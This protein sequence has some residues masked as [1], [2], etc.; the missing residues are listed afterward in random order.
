MTDKNIRVQHLIIETTRR[1]KL[2]CRHCLR[3]DAQDLDIDVLF[4]KELFANVSEIDTIT[5]TGGEPAMNCY[6]MRM[7]LS[8]AIQ[9]G[10]RVRNIYVATN[11]QDVSRDFLT[12]I[13]EW[14]EYCIACEY[15]ASDRPLSPDEAARLIRYANDDEMPVGATVALSLDAFHG[16]VPAVNV[17]RLL[18]LPRLV[19]DKYVDGKTRQSLIPEGRAKENGLPCREPLEWQYE[20]QYTGRLEIELDDPE[21]PGAYAMIEELYLN[22][23]GNILRHCDWS[24]E[25]QEKFIIDTITVP[26]WMDRLLAKAA[27]EYE[28]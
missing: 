24:Y 20:E 22:A 10:V 21:N 16:T 13:R 9:Y 2:K 18:T 19:L 4:L 26:G 28:S 1:C 6:A 25:T 12:A 8:Y 14:H 5:F 23:K 17:A 3:G 7:A 11:G 15:E 27:Q